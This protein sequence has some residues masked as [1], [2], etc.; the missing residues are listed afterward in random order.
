MSGPIYNR[1]IS[2]STWWNY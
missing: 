1:Y 2:G